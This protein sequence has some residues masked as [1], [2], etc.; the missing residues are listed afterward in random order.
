[1]AATVI[2]IEQRKLHYFPGD[3]DAFAKRHAAFVT[4]QRRK[5]AAEQR[6]L[7]KLQ[8]ATPAARGANRSPRGWRE[9]P[10]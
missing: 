5:A 1:M 8:Q 9:L 2:L 10:S 6:E 3:Y 4:E 7:H